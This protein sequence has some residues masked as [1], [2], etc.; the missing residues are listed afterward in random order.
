MVVVEKHNL[1]VIATYK[2]AYVSMKYVPSVL[3]WMSDKQCSLYT[4]LLYATR[5]EAAP[6][7]SW[8]VRGRG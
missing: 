5:K 6:P 7:P 4:C 2:R 8:F 3:E 1:H